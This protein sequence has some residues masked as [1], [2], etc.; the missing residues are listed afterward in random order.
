MSGERWIRTRRQRFLLHL[1][2]P[3]QHIHDL[4]MNTDLHIA[5]LA[6]EP[7]S[8]VVGRSQIEQ[9]CPVGGMRQREPA[10]QNVLSCD[11]RQHRRIALRRRR[12][13]SRGPDVF[14]L[15]KHLDQVLF[16]LG[17]EP[18]LDRLT[19]TSSPP[20]GVPSLDEPLLATEDGPHRGLLDA[21]VMS[22]VSHGELAESEDRAKDAV[23][24]EHRSTP[25]LVLR[26]VIRR[27]T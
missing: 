6:D 24:M 22:Q 21:A 23:A 14:Q 13:R 11:E 17:T 3:N 19:A 4:K 7:G 18:V 12:R 27:C 15:P 8:F 10:Q 9:A 1:G 20:E 5:G 26:R 2:Q 16:G 25:L